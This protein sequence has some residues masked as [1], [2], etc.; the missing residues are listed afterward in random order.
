MRAHVAPPLLSLSLSLHSACTCA[1]AFLARACIMHGD[2]AEK[3]IFAVRRAEMYSPNYLRIGVP[4]LP[5]LPLLSP[6]TAHSKA[7]PR[8]KERPFRPFLLSSP[9]FPP[10]PTVDSTFAW[11]AFI[12][13][14]PFFQRLLER[15]VYPLPPRVYCARLPSIRVHEYTRERERERECARAR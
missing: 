13:N 12:W 4:N 1:A 5:P 2:P 6:T 14:R 3:Y 11:N 7:S 9:P 15:A 8:S 10:F